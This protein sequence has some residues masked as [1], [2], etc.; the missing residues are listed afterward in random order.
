LSDELSLP[1]RPDSVRTSVEERLRKAIMRGEFP[2]GTH[3]SD[4]LLCTRFGASRSIVREAIRPL[5]AEGLVILAPH[6]GPFVASL[7]VA[8]AVQIYEVR[9]ALEAL[10]GQGFA[11]R[12][13]EEERAEL[14][15]I[16]ERLEA[17]GAGQD[18]LLQIKRDFYAVLLRGCRNAY[19]ER[20]LG[21]MLN[22]V[23]LLR[24]ASM[25]EAGR[26]PH[27][28]QEL[29]RIV[30]AIEARDGEGTA[31]ACRDHVR[32]ALSA[33]LRVLRQKE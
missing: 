19:A 14:R 24:A 31:A 13:S 2:P 9:G 7:G 22:R 32:S 23:T 17:T 11:E 25:S 30:E 10:A 5:E 8:E 20:L 29:R 21:Q 18:E 15:R 1:D 3:L 33:A 12:A 28:I 27:T 6:R 4:R 16:F 26:L